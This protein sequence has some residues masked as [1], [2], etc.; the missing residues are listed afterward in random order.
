MRAELSVHRFVLSIL[1]VWIV[2]FV[3]LLVLLGAEDA[4]TRVAVE[5]ILLYS[6][7]VS[8]AFVGMGMIEFMA[9]IEL[10]WKHRREAAT[11][12]VL[13]SIALASGLFLATRPNVSLQTI[14]LVVAPHALLLGLT[15]LRMAAHLGHHRRQRTAL[16]V[17]GFMDLAAALML[18]GTEFINS[19]WLIVK[20]LGL[21]AITALLQFIPLL[22]LQKS[23]LKASDRTESVKSAAMHAQ[24][25]F[26]RGAASGR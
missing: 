20:I 10:G 5:I 25:R 7:V 17:C 8:A 26:A 2:I 15:Q 9:A 19:E 4:G 14:S 6:I 3:A 18:A 24:P 16:A 21:T 1:T 13:A 12:C 11:Y 22:F 23:D